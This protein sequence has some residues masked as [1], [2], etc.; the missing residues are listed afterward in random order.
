[1]TGTNWT[2]LTQSPV[3]GIYIYSFSSPA[4]VAIDPAGRIEV[5]DGN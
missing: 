4:H 3:I 2:T 1:M 5:G